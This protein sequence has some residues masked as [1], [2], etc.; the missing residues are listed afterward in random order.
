MEEDDDDDIPIVTSNVAKSRKSEDATAS[1]AYQSTVLPY[2]N[3]KSSHKYSCKPIT[4]L[5]PINNTHGHTK[6]CMDQNCTSK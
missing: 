2:I 6:F 5:I 1:T 3:H 4:I